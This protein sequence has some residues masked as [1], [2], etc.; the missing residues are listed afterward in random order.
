M[1]DIYCLI[2]VLVQGAG[3]NVDAA[4][5]MLVEGVVL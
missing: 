5:L 2:V 3:I 4:V 1:R